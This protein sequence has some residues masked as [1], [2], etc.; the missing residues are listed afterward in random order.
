MKRR[1]PEETPLWPIRTGEG[2]R[3]IVGIGAAVAVWTGAGA[4]TTTGA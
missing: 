4:E 3:G 2:E 1:G